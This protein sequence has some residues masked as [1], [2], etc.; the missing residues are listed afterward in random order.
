MLTAHFI[1]TLYM[2]G[3]IWFV[4][5]VHYPLFAEVGEDAFVAY[6]AAHTQRTSI[7]VMG[8]MLVELGTAIGLVWMR[9]ALISAAEAWIGLGLVG[10]IWASTFV[11]QV[12]AHTRLGQGFDV[13]TARRLVRTNWIR[14]VAWTARA[15]L[16]ALWIQ[17]YQGI[18]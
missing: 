16:C 15:G 1:A 7:A 10:V 5:L 4:Q 14:T 18:G 8:A 17:R 11:L 2:T 13:A 9:P 12:P 6:E 3:L